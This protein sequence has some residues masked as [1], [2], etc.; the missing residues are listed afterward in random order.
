VVFKPL[1][2][3]S[4]SL[5]LPLLEHQAGSRDLKVGGAAA[6]PSTRGRKKGHRKRAAAV[7]IAL[8]GG[9]LHGGPAGETGA[10]TGAPL[11]SD[12]QR[13]VRA[14]PVCPRLVQRLDSSTLVY[15]PECQP[16]EPFRLATRA[17]LP[18]RCVV[19]SLLQRGGHPGPVWWSP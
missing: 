3:P 7:A 17:L 12:R 6:A 16:P 13:A 8:A 9:A 2:T 10:G 15:P 14:R 11:V 5:F 19:V 1:K 4:F 18:P